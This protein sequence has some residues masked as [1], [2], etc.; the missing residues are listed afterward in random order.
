MSALTKFTLFALLLVGGATIHGLSISTGY[1][2]LIEQHKAKGVLSDGTLYNPKITGAE[3]VD[4]FLATLVQFFSPCTDGSAPGL[5][6]QSSLFAVQGFAFF[7]IWLLEG[8][9]NGN[10]GKLVSFISVYGLL[11]QAG[12]LALIAPAYLL[13]YVITSPTVATPAPSN[14]AIDPAIL[15][16]IPLAFTLGFLP[17]TIFM[18]LPSPSVISI[19]TK[20]R[21]LALW[22]PVPLYVILL[23][24]LWKLFSGS[25]PN[26]TM[27]K[28][29]Q[30]QRLRNV[31]K[32]GLAFAVPG[33]AAIWALSLTALVLPHI[34]N[35]SVAAEF[36]PLSALVP[37]NPFAYAATTV[38]SLA[39]GALNFLQ[40]DY[41]ISSISYLVF[42][43]SARFNARVEPSGFSVG[44]MFGLLTR[45]CVL[46]PM[47]TALS[48]LWERDE[49][50]LGRD[51]G[52]KKQR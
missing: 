43:L 40:W 24:R 29:D 3:A 5:S 44:D 46:G 27:S 22:Q 36:H 15:S 16:G 25:P 8:Y 47:G 14:L 23:L 19:D 34:Y 32:F 52:Q 4:D 48:Y 26:S 1:Y 12:G 42:S 20:V 35:P 9:R 6:L 37:A 10:K 33:H 13:L 31:Y 2:E 28:Q 11:F 39:Q 7:M 38:T 30:L 41:I 49:I 50:V 51:E 18:N 21:A 17:P 45:I